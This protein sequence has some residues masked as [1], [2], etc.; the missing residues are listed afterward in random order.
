LRSE[1]LII[2][3]GLPFIDAPAAWVSAPAGSRAHLHQSAQEEAAA[4]GTTHRCR[5]NH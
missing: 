4:A 3:R 5:M 1:V 2:V